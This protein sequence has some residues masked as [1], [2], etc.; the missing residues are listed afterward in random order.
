MRK[1][2]VVVGMMLM[3]SN[4]LVAYIYISLLYKQYTHNMAFTIK[5]FAII[6]VCLS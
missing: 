5:T 1:W 6:F 2:T 3:S 4:C